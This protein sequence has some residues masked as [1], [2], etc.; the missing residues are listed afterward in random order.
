MNSKLLAQNT[1]TEYQ[2]L[3]PINFKNPNQDNGQNLTIDVSQPK[4]DADKD[5]GFNNYLND[6]FLIVLMAVIIIAVFMLIYGGVLYL[7][8]DIGSKV[9]E[10]KKIIVGVFSGIVFVFSV[11]LIFYIVN[12]KFLTSGIVFN[13]IKY[14]EISTPTNTT[15]DSDG[16]V[17]T[18]NTGADYASSA[19]TASCTEGTT[20]TTSPVINQ[21]G[22]D[23]CN[24]LINKLKT[25][26]NQF[27][28]Q[29]IMTSSIRDKDSQSNCH[30][31]NNPQS[32]SCADIVPSNGDYDG[33]CKVILN[34]GGIGILNESGKFA[35]NCGG[36][37]VNT[38]YGTGAHLHVNLLK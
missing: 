27:G 14:V 24:T 5:K 33:L 37:S 26:A 10:G 7:T 2:L 21:P 34:V 23:V 25:A 9:S 28:G 35:P 38:K 12:P 11:W 17:A 18:V 36:A 4:T 16:V 19:K 29:V 31:S 13:I 6:I 3:E 20:K 22:Q 8:K 32:G 15:P 30:K 1:K